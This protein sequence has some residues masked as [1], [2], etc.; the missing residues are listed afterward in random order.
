MCA[1]VAPTVSVLGY[2]LDDHL[3]LPVMP[4][5]VPAMMMRTVPSGEHHRR[6]L[7][8]HGAAIDRVS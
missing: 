2:R 5:S 6:L 3:A 4:P 1:L 7:N 8:H